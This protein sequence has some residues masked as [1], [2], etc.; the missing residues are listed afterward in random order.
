MYPFFVLD[1]D[2]DATD[3]DVER[4]YHE[5]IQQYPP[6]RAPE[7]FAAIRCAY[8]ALRDRRSRLKAWLFS[9]DSIGRALSEG[10]M[11]QRSPRPSRRLSSDELAKLLKEAQ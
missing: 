2:L 3:D 11:I 7:E 1:L 8:E 5:L 10:T 6:D 9:F 4:R